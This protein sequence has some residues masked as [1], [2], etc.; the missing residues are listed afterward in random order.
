M[1]VAGV[2]LTC[3]KG[4]LLKLMDCGSFQVQGN[5]AP[6]ASIWAAS[7]AVP[8]QTLSRDHTLISL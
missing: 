4:N 1:P 5:C 7:G 2:G 6:S 8:V 3:D